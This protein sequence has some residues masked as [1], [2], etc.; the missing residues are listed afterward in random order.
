MVNEQPVA[1]KI[2]SSHQKQYFQNERDIYTLP[3]MDS[4]SLLTYFG[5]DER[6]TM[7][8][9]VEYLLVLSLAPLGCLQDF[10]VENTTSFNVFCKMAKSVARGLSHLHTEIRKGELIKPCVCHRDLNSRNI[11]VKA[12]LSC[13]ICDLGFSLKTFGS[14]YEYRGEM[15]LAETKSINEVGTIR[16]MAPEVLEGAVNLRDCESALKQIDVYSLGLVLWELCTRCYELY[17]SE[18]AVPIYKTAYEEEIGTHPSFEDMQ[19]LVS[20]RKARPLFLP[21]WGGQTA[22]AKIARETCEDCWDHDAEARLTA[23]CVEERLQEMS[24]LSPNINRCTSPPLSTKNLI[25]PITSPTSSNNPI[26]N[27]VSVTVSIDS[28]QGHSSSTSSPSSATSVESTAN[29]KSYK[30]RDINQK[31][32]QPYQGRNLCL[33]RNLTP[34]NPASIQQ[35]VE[36]S[37]KH[38]TDIAAEFLEDDVFVEEYL[39]RTIIT[40]PTSTQ[41]HSMGEGFPKKNN[42]EP[43]IKT[44]KSGKG[45][46]EVRSMIQKTLFSRDGSFSSLNNEESD[47]GSHKQHNL[48]KLNRNVHVNLIDEFNSAENGFKSNT[49]LFTAAV[50]PTRPNNLDLSTN[51]NH[52]QNADKQNVNSVGNKNNFK[53]YKKPPGDNT[54]QKFT[55]INS[56]GPRIVVSKSANAVKNLNSNSRESIIDDRQLKRQRSLEVFRDV[57]GPKGSV[58]RLRDPSQ[59]VKTPGDVPPSVR[60]VRASKTLSLYDDRMMYPSGNPI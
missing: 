55:V 43:V 1:V 59:R 31:Q 40:S 18:Q 13:C 42:Y 10:L 45:W 56:T 11:L 34:Q 33:E 28:N 30:N 21:C 2:F 20:R 27:G 8:D 32:L 22:A 14:R 49:T 16:Y 47:M 23:L 5:C 53:L 50:I 19:V 35:L 26:P 38:S 15:T 41:Q 60:K 17:P 6:H 57:F 52:E 4:P 29:V 37:S 39:T 48:N 51:N 3:M 24:T 58:E 25:V 44:G 36:R 9:N 54:N 7:E 46:N 12:D